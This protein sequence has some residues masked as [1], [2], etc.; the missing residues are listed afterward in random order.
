M[1]LRQLICLT[2]LA[3]YLLA[4]LPA[5]SLST[6]TPTPT[7]AESSAAAAE[8]AASERSKMFE[9]GLAYS[10]WID[11]LARNTGSQFWQRRVVDHVTWARLFAC[12]VALVLLAGITG[13]LTVVVRRTAGAIE[14]DEQQSWFALAASALRKPLALIIWVIGGFL[15][16]MPLVAGISSHP[17]R[18]F[19]A[20]I[21]TAILY[22]GRVIAV[23]WLI[24]Q[25]IRALE[26][27]MRHW[28]QS[29]GSVFNNVM[30]PLVGQTLRLAVPLLAV[31][32]LLP[33]LELPPEWAWLTQKGFGVLL[34]V[35]LAFLI[36]RGVRTVQ[37]ALLR[38]HRMDVA[39]NYT[40]RRIY[41]QVS[42]VRKLITTVVIVL[43]VGSILMMF[44]TMR[45][46]GTSILASAGIA[47]IILG[48]A[49]QKTLGN[50]L[51]GIQI[52]LSQPILI[53]DVV[54]VEGEFGRIEDITLTFVAVRTWDLRRLI[55]PITYFIEKPFQNWSRKS[56]E[57]LGTVYLY[58]DYQV[59]LGEL[60]E[61]VKRLVEK[62]ENWDRKVCGL[63]V[64]DTKPNT[65][66]VRVL[67]S[68]LNAGKNFDLRCQVREGLIEFLRSRYPES[69]PRVR[70]ATEQL[71]ASRGP[72]SQHA[73][74]VEGKEH[75]RGSSAPGLE[76]EK[77]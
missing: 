35:S 6:P 47:G 36:I 40:A 49:A 33:L 15:A 76:S 67:V 77:E 66:E 2:T 71:D 62:N 4:S 68:S 8:H 57:I 61:E 34:I 21:L 75:E 25:V 70:I 7:P 44:D 42:V 20:N 29:T 65:I 37:N 50:L 11:G 55:V 26:K 73:E 46:L 58:L 32:L 72:E 10:K 56:D 59:P 13:S 17:R 16:F 1:R 28:A 74:I 51:A 30:V 14:S 18:I 48:F 45:Q 43:G 69:L 9:A 60:R 3:F 31:I 52:A 27:R 23:L 63:Q 38:E 39:D 54:I 64:T 53:D 12:L 24:F 22:A 19:F 5:W 41:T